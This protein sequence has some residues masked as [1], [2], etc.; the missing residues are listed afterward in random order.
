MKEIVFLT[1]RLP[2]PASSGRK[3]VMYNYCKI[4]HE[5]YGYDITIISYLEEGDQPK[6]KPDFIKDVIVLPRISTKQKIKNLLLK[7]CVQRNWPMQVSLFWSD[8]NATQIKKQLEILK[9]EVVIADMVRM[10]EYSKEYTGY[11]IADLDDMISVRYE[12]QLQQDMR[13]VN[14][15]G[16]YLYSLPLAAQKILSSTAIKKIVL[17]NEVQLLKKYEIETAQKHNK[18][19][20]V[21][22]HEAQILNNK[23]GYENAVGVPLGVDVSYY[24]EYYGKLKKK[25][26]TIAFLGAMSVA[27]NEAGAIHFIQNILP[28]VKECEPDAQFIVV[29]GGVTEKLRSLKSESVQFTGRVEDVRTVVG[30]CE[31]F[32]CPLTFGSGIKTKILEAMAMGVSVVTTTVGAENINAVDGRD[33]IIADDNRKFANAVVELMHNADKRQV[34]EES[35][36]HFVENCFTWKV[37][38]NRLKDCLPSGE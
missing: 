35:A 31:V 7:T 14:P 17:K 34:L 38:E 5:T 3:N 32:V 22:E 33:W 20:F 15:Y 21:A 8:E 11:K 1:A 19:I 2:Y 16:A 13:M 25:K 4:L 18:T 27:H 12:R 24:G 29:G 23:L 28:I 36:F 26:N 9:P 10:T 30:E 6:T 37:A